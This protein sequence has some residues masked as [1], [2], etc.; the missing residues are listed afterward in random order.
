[1]MQ[2]LRVFL[3]ARLTAAAEEIFGAVEKTISDYK[4]EICRSKDLEIGRLRMQIKILKSGRFESIQC[5]V[6][7]GGF[8]PQ[9]SHAYV[10]CFFLLLL[11]CI[12]LYTV[13]CVCGI[14]VSFDV[15][16]PDPLSLPFSP[17]DGEVLRHTATAHPSA[18][19]PSINP[20][21]PCGGGLRDAALRDG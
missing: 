14:C 4:E 6:V 8:F 21:C 5:A 16:K 9:I 1:M 15:S 11:F 17:S 10:F 19:A 7:F 3:N 18:A 2:S 20:R 12:L 13:A